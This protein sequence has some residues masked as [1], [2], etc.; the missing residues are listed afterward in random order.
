MPA[1]LIKQQYE[2][3]ATLLTAYRSGP[4]SSEL[5][6]HT[7]QFCAA[8]LH[9]AKTHPDA[10]F[11]QLQLYKKKLPYVYNLTFN[12][13]LYSALLSAR[14]K[15][16]DTT[17]QQIM[18]AS[19]TLFA[20]EQKTIEQYYTGKA[21][22]LAGKLNQRLC[23]VLQKTRQETWLGGYQLCTVIHRN[24]GEQIGQL[25]RVS[26]D[27]AILLIAARLALL[28]T[29]NTRFKKHNFAEA[30]RKTILASPAPCYPLFAPL[31]DYPGLVP[32]G[33]Y[34]RLED[35]RYAVVL[36]VTSHELIVC[37][38]GAK[39]ENGSA[40]ISRLDLHT[41]KRSYTAK[42]FSRFDK[43]NQWWGKN[44]AQYQAALA[45]APGAGLCTPFNPSYNI[46]RP[47]LTLVDIQTQLNEPEQDIKKLAQAIAK[48]PAFA[49][50]LQNTASQSSREKL[51][52]VAIQHSLMMHGFARS[53]SIIMQ[54]ALLN[55]V[56]QHYFP[57]QHY[58]INFTQLRGY[59][60]SCLAKECDLGLPEQA[61]TLAYF[62]NS[63]LFTHAALKSQTQWLRGKTQIF[64]IGQLIVCQNS[65]QLGLQGV[66]LAQAWHQ[67]RHEI[68]AL[69]TCHHMP[70]PQTNKDDAAKLAALLGMSLLLARQ[71]FFAEPE[72]CI[73][74]QQYLKEALILLN[75]KPQD[76]ESIKRQSVA[77]CHMYCP[78]G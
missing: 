7:L 9:L 1:D 57:L 75:L 10:T 21:D 11:A 6:R 20:F 19:I 38:L 46:S 43:I 65:R 68:V 32:P 26:K 3:L 74:G 13:C 2:S 23:Q 42:G 76:I 47:P 61:C 72:L 41:I 37:S 45:P 53:G 25:D 66:S 64:D 31:L 40:Q 27:Q 78:I 73:Q 67:P 51:P 55:R 44:W 35:T 63:G 22:P 48:E 30:L 33:S 60:A 54:Q 56:N 16:N 4:L 18:C 29:A 34:V 36:G 69:S 15:I 62:A 49:V 14:N 5:I 77:F 71:V 12:C 52:V 39:D 58:F 8:L 50:H 70:K 17:S 59:F 24:L 28:T